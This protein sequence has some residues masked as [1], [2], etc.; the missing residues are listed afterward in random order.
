M[1]LRGV[2][3]ALQEVGGTLQGVEEEEEGEEEVGVGLYESTNTD[4]LKPDVLD[5]NKEEEREEEEYVSVDE[6]TIQQNCENLDINTIQD[7]N[8]ENIEENYDNVDIIGSGETI[9]QEAKYEKSMLE[10]FI[11]NLITSST[12]SFLQTIWQI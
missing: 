10:K 3:K 5:E 8:M 2:V 11:E 4:H 12:K 6:E 9:K 1:L 7:E